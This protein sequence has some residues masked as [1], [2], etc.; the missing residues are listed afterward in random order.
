MC[1]RATEIRRTATHLKQ[2]RPDAK[3]TGWSEDL[4]RRWLEKMNSGGSGG[5]NGWRSWVMLTAAS[6]EAA[7]VTLVSGSTY[8]AGFGNRSWPKW[9]KLAINV[10]TGYFAVRTTGSG[11]PWALACLVRYIILRKVIP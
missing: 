2:K 1:G 6:V 3:T 5:E 4:K 11:P 8:Y 9:A 7:R 10:D